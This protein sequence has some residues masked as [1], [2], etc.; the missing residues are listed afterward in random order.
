VQNFRFN[1]SEQF[2]GPRGA[3]NSQNGAANQDKPREPGLKSDQ[4][5]ENFLK[6]RRNHETRRTVANLKTFHQYN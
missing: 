1:I 4:S 6:K 3:H 5:L 2:K